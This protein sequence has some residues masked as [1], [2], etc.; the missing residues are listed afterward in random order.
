MCV[1]CVYLKKH[2][3]A[4]VPSEHPPVR[5][6]GEISKH[7]GGIIGCKDKKNSSWHLNGFL[8]VLIVRLG[9]QYHFG[10]KREAHRYTI[11]LY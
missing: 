7:L 4:Y 10:E 3:N 5:A 1:C 8:M 9:Q 6:G 11:H 2:L